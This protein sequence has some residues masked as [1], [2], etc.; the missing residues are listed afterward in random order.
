M[1]SA[2]RPEGPWAPLIQ[3]VQISGWEDPCP[4]WD[5]NGQA[6]LGHSRVGAGPIIIHKLSADGKKLLDDGVTVYTGPVAEGTKIYKL[7][8]YYYL[9]IPEGGVGT[10][11]QTILRSKNI[12]GPY[13]KKVVL[14]TGLTGINGPHLSAPQTSDEFNDQSL[15]FQWSWNHN[16]VR[17]AWS[18]SSNPGFLALNGLPAG[19]FLKA[20]NT[21]TQKIMGDEGEATTLLLTTEMGNGQKAGLCVMGKQYNLIGIEKVN[22]KLTLFVNINGKNSTQTFRSSKVY[23]KVKVTTKE[24]GNQFFYSTDNKTFQPSGDTFSASNG[25]WKGPKTGLFSYNETGE[26]GKALFNWFHYLY[27]GPKSE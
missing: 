7:N 11:W 9:S 13:E 22:G 4:F 6:Y 27:D 2:E 26:G 23:L 15:S 18:L 10:G 8:G 25:Y 1:T 3:V 5:E 19:N 21:L 16:P 17:E 12:F 20:K 14:E 24:G